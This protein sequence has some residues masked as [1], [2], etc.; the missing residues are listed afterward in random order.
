MS[1]T[2][3][4]ADQHAAVGLRA[5]IGLGAVPVDHQTAGDRAARVQPPQDDV[6]VVPARGDDDLPVGHPQ[7]RRA[8]ARRS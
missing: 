5:R 4:E 3:D 6:V 2:P 1:L 8:A 7:I